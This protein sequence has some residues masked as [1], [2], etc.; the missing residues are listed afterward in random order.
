MDGL[1][2]DTEALYRDAILSACSALGY[3]MHPDTHRSMIGVPTDRVNEILLESFGPEFPLVRFYQQC[4]IY[5]DVRCQEAVPTRLGA[6]ELLE[7]LTVR[8]IPTAVATSTGRKT[9]THH[10]K[11]TGLLEFLDTVVARDDVEHHPETY[12]TAA[13]WLDIDPVN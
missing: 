6:F 9:A 13:E 8:G 10:L 7:A 1:L 4:S 11:S 5:V 3:A 2:L 12:L